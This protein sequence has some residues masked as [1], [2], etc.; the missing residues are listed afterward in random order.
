MVDGFPDCVLYSVV[1]IIVTTQCLLYGYR[2]CSQ[3]SPRAEGTDHMPRP[4]CFEHLLQRPL[5]YILF[6]FGI[7]RGVANWKDI[8]QC[9]WNGTFFPRTSEVPIHV[10]IHCRP[11]LWNLLSIS[12]SSSP[13]QIY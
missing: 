12:I 1:T 9:G 11:I 2:D 6:S 8:L 13:F 4:H 3:S 5:F 10:S 7:Q